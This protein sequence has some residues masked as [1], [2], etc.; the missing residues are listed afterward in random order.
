MSEEKIS[1]A[2]QPTPGEPAYVPP[3][4]VVPIPSKGICYPV[5]HPFHGVDRVE[6]K[7]MT[8]KEEDILTSTALIKQGKAMSALIR[9]CLLN[10]TVDPDELL[11]G[12]RNA[13]LMAIR[14]TGY[15][16]EYEVEVP[17][18]SCG[19]AVKYTF[20]LR[21]IDVTGLPSDVSPVE[22]G[23]N[24]FSFK[25]PV[26]KKEVIFKLQTGASSREVDQ[27][28]EAAKRKLGPAAETP[29]TTNLFYHIVSIGGETDRS[30]LRGIV[31]KLPAGDS[32]ALRMYMDKISP[33]VEMHQEM[34]CPHCD[35]VTEAD[36]PMTTE[37]FWPSAE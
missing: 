3:T 34:K 6:I 18:G 15:G 26:M 20:D 28:Q 32:R 14:I 8:A 5:D 23:Q 16:P 31:N 10:K 29:V 22:P 11:T 2:N 12:D 25:L 9:S 4:D 33:G 21:K 17:C 35:A 30:K 27:D 37:F 19:E 36:V 13:L 24:K 1:L 7:S